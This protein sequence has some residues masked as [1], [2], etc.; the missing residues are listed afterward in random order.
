MLITTSNFASSVSVSLHTLSHHNK[1][2]KSFNNAFKSHFIIGD[3]ITKP[4][5]KNNFLDEK[6]TYS[7]TDSLV[8]DMTNKKAYLYNNAVVVYGDMKLQAGYIELDFGRNMIYSRGIKDS[9][10]KIVQK[11]VSEQGTEKFKAGEITYNFKTK[12][13]KIKDVI[14]QQGEGFILGRDIKKDSSG[15]FYVG[16]GKYTTCDKEDPHF[17]IGA[18]KIKVIQDDKIITGPAQLYLADIPTPLAIPFGFFPNKKGRASG[19]LMP[20]YGESQQ[21][22]FFLKNGGFYI[23]KNEYIDLALTGDVYANSGFAIRTNSNYK[24]RYHYNGL[25][26]LSYSHTVIGSLA[27]A[28]AIKQTNFAI[29]WNHSQDS[30]ANPSSLFSAN[31]NAGSSSNNKIN[32]NPTGSYLQN[33]YQSSISYRK[34]FIGTPFN[35]SANARHS[36]STINKRVDITLPELALTMNRI[37]P[38]K[39]KNRVGVKWYDKIFITPTANAK[40]QISSG[41]STLFKPQTLKKMQNGLQFN[42]PINASFNFLKYFNFS[43]GITTSSR[44]YYQ[45]V[46]KHYGLSKDSKKDSI[47]TDTLQGVKMANDFSLSANLNTIVYGN[48]F[49]KSNYLKQI[50]HVITPSIG[51]SFRPDFSESKYGYYKTISS[52]TGATH[53]YSMFQNGIYGGPG[54]GKSGVISFGLN[55]TL[56]AKVKQQSD[57]GATIKKVMLIDNFSANTSYNIAAKTFK[58]QSVN[59]AARTKLFKLL[60]VNTNAIIDPYQTSQQGKRIDRLE[61]SKGKIGRLTSASAALGTS[62]HSKTKTKTKK[63]ASPEDQDQID[64]INTHPNAYIDFNVPW[65]LTVSYNLQYSKT[66]A[67][68]LDGFQKTVTQTA[69]FSGDLSLTQKW[70]ISVSSGFDFETKKLSLTSIDIY[71]DLHCW[72]MSFNWIP[73]GFRQSYSLNINVKSSVLRDLKLT[74]RR[75]WQDYQ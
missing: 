63:D 35:F 9:S 26:N 51:A 46:E 64:Y 73:F 21:M 29:N 19:L 68:T 25:V 22:G 66:Q 67:S 75:Q 38:F 39:N 18:K 31:V 40:N 50:R 10:G 36:Q 23:G 12:K 72:E 1:G 41:D 53:Q 6:V 20:T 17:Y 3:T 59:L 56:E 60:D 13:G 30:K 5:E 54:A 74:R 45:T 58:W 62:L 71:R 2:F 55:N 27:F 16:H 52:S 57:S 28:N 32:G 61:W 48:Y 4:E 69:R 34:T 37:S 14:T 11:P 42:A 44:I 15:V 70:K 49:F 43:P 7:A 8:L 47:L 65:N 24:N 33:T